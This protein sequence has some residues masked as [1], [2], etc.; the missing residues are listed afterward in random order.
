MPSNIYDVIDNQFSKLQGQLNCIENNDKVVMAMIETLAEMQNRNRTLDIIEKQLSVLNDEIKKESAADDK[1]LAILRET[2]RQQQL[3][4]LKALVE[5]EPL[6]EESAC[7][8][9]AS[10]E[11]TLVSDGAE[12]KTEI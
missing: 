10:N 2:T 4:L 6:K 5:G 3:A 1:E 8:A 11:E 9:S 7:N 12:I